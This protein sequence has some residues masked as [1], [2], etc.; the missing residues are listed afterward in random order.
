MVSAIHLYTG[1]E[2]VYEKNPEWDQVTLHYGKIKRTRRTFI[3]KELKYAV[4]WR[5][6]IFK[7]RL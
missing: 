6:Y 2:S 1:A 7:D 3:F 5:F 4:S